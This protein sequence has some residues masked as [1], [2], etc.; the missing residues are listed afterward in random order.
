MSVNIDFTPFHITCSKGQIYRG[1]R[2]SMIPKPFRQVNVYLA[3][4]WYEPGVPKGYR[5]DHIIGFDAAIKVAMDLSLSG[6]E[7]KDS[8]A[9]RIVT[10]LDD[11]R[12]WSKLIFLDGRVKENWM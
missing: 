2:P 3:G 11:G 4:K 8:R 5:R 6:K 10:L 1:V 12:K 7:K 9:Y